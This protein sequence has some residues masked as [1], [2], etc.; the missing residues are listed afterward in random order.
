MDTENNSSE[1]K[2]KKMSKRQ[3]WIRFCLWSLFAVVAP[4]AFLAWRYGLF[5]TVQSEAQVKTSLSGW[6]IMAVIIVSFFLLY[7]VKEAKK[8]V[9][10]SSMLSQCLDGYS[11][12]IIPFL[13]V[14]MLESIKDNIENFIEL[15]IAIIICEA[16]AIPINPMRRWAFENKIDIQTNIIS[17]AIKSALGKKSGK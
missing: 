15:L 12:L 4:I 11:L 16:I 9:P 8:S 17:E 2:I 3:F 1:I 5:T 7:I 13:L 10:K 14:L 6:G